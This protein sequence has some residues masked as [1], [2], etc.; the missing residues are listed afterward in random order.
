MSKRYD[1]GNGGAAWCQGCYTM[2]EVPTHV[3]D[4]GREF[5]FGDYVKSSD[6]DTAVTA[7]KEIAA[8]VHKAGPSR[9]MP[10]QAAI[11]ARAALDALGEK[12]GSQP[13]N[14]SEK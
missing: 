8:E 2:E 12:W 10:T 11:K 5:E 1:C 13:E 7:L 4:D 6:Y 14:G 3:T 9:G